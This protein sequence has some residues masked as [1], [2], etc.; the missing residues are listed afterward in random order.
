MIKVGFLEVGELFYDCEK[1]F[2]VVG[3][4]FMVECDFLRSRIFAI[5]FHQNKAQVSFYF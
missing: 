2:E 4:C 5:V 1:L 3:G